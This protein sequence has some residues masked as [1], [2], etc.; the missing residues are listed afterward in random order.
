MATSL[1]PP[2]TAT[3]LDS[4]T[5]TTTTT[6]PETA[7]LT[8]AVDDLLNTLRAKFT[9]ATSAMLEKMDDMSRRLDNLEAVLSVQ[10]ENQGK[11]QGEATKEGS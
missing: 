2:T 11:H 9:A 3:N 6:N 5:T 7:E 1:G 10:D 4:P 8:A